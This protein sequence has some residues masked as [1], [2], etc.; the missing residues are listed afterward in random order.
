[1]QQLERLGEQGL[2][3]TDY[4]TPPIADTLRARRVAFLDTAGNAYLPQAPS[5]E[6]LPCLSFGN[7]HGLH[8]LSN[9]QTELQSGLRIL[10][11]RHRHCLQHFRL[12]CKCVQ[13]TRSV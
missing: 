4:V 10:Y 2:L 9:V 13:T 5:Q 6:I 3:V 8:K 12:V 1:L 7:P 11:G